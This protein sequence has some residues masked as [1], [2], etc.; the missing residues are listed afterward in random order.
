MRLTK[1]VVVGLVFF[2]GIGLLVYLTMAIPLINPTGG[3]NVKAHFPQ[4]EGLARGD[5]VWVDGYPMGK[6]QD[7][8]LASNGGVVAMLHLWKPISLREGYSIRIQASAIL[9]GKVVALERGNPKGKEIQ[10]PA[11]LEGRS[12]P[13]VMESLKNL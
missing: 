12:S 11:V 9:G 4:A 1:D 8:E 6:V 7:I 5:V 2:L 3:S 10:A 13:E